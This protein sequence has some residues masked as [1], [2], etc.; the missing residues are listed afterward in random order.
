MQTAE[1]Q[2]FYQSEN[3]IPPRDLKRNSIYGFA[4]QNSAMK[5]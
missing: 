1:F 5:F 3:K 2:E 4:G